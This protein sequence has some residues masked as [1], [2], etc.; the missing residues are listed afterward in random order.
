M[1][2]YRELYIYIYI[3]YIYIYIYIYVYGK[4][5]RDRHLD[6]LIDYKF[7]L[8]EREMDV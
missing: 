6:R 3:L 1:D 2:I 5:E 8:I 7:K 4:I